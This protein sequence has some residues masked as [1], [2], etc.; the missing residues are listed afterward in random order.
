MSK[1]DYD[2]FVIGAGS[3]GVRAGRLAASLGKKV[4]VAEEYRPGGTCVIR[5]CVPKKY[6]VF[7][8]EF[9]KALKEAK[10]YGWSADNVRFDWAV[11]RDEIQTEVSRLSNIYSNILDKNGA[12]L[13]LERAE[14]TGPHTIKL[15]DSN[16]EV[17]ARHILIATGGTPFMPPIQGMD[18]AISSNEAFTLEALPER[19]M[20]IGGGYIACEFAG[21]FAGLGCKTTQVYRGDNLLRGFDEEVRDAVT[22]GQRLNGINVKFGQSPISVKKIGNGLKVTFEDGIQIGTDLIMM[23]TGRVPNTHGLG[24]ENAGVKLNEKGAVIVDAYSQSS[25]KHIYAVG[26]VTDR[27]NLTPV[28]I[29]EGAAF[30]E[31]VY[32]NNPVAYDHG[33]IASGVF[34]MPPAGVVG[35][36]EAQAREKHKDVKVYKTSFRPMKNLLSGS[37]HRCFMKLIT[38]GKKEKVIGV[39]IVGDYAAEIIQAVGIAVKAGLTK[40]QFD[41]TCA[42]HPTLAEELVTL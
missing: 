15:Q 19:V 38:T 17:T 8:A 28:A 37:E 23:A 33:D 5:G 41:A 2:L 16:R 42:V 39:H 1:Y 10:G 21:I 7:G 9:G 26:D 27:V 34:T 4:A 18:H 29:R 20:V 31:T 12:D 6:L 14:L 40:A 36:S 30:I 22:A 35:L 25:V 13:I 24:L 11:L 3:G 32:K